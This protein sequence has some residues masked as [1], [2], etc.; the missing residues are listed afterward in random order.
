[1]RGKTAGS[2]TRI[3]VNGKKKTRIP[4]AAI[5]TDLIASNEPVKEET[6][7]VQAYLKKGNKKRGKKIVG[8]RSEKSTDLAYGRNYYYTK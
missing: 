6:G 4:H 7:Q 8:E 2:G 5:S 3:Q 1:M